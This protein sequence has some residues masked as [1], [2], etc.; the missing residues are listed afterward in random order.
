MVS[1]YTEAVNWIHGRLKL[2]VKPGLKRM[3]W[4]LERLGHPERRVKAVHVAGTNGKGSTVCF[5]R[6][7]LQEAGYSVGTFTS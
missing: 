5:L 7:I 3:E 4:M 6:H 2:G 1:T